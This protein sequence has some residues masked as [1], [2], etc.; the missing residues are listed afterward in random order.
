MDGQAKA[1][2]KKVTGK[3]TLLLAVYNLNRS[4]LVSEF[5]VSKIGCLKL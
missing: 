1:L 2:L 5:R 4:V 3:A